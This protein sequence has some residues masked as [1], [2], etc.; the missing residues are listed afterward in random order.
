MKYHIGKAIL[1]DHDKKGST[2]H[3][4]KKYLITNYNFNNND[5]LNKTIKILLEKTTGERLIKNIYHAGH[6]KLSHEFKKALIK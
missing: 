5:L 2:R 1:A 6:Y 4:I 3:A